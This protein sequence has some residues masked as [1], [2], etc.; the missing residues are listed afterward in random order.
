MWRVRDGHL[1][2]NAMQ[3]SVWQEAG[4]EEDMLA[5][6]L[7]QAKKDLFDD[8]DRYPDRQILYSGKGRV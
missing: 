5:A 8:L 4:K 1:A 6:S 3:L 2:W 7:K